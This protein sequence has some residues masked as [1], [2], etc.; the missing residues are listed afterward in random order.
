MRAI[1]RVFGIATVVAV[2][3]CGSGDPRLMNIDAG[4]TTPD[5]FAILP[6]KPLS[7]PPD[8]AVLPAP[9]PGGGNITDPTPRADAIATLGGDPGAM[10][11]QGIGASDQALVGYAGRA[12]VRPEI[13]QELALADLAWRRRHAPRPLERLFNSNVYLRAYSRM[14]LNPHAEQ[15]RWQR[16]G[17]STPA[18]PPPP[19]D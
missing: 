6:T 10:V 12:G 16:A 4:Q 18:A 13:R 3:A 2:S 15:L 5:E 19:R 7:M 14:S 11:D 1:M 8:L 9:T 17:A